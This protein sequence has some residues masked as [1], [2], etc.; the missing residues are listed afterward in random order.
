[1]IATLVLVGCWLELVMVVVAVVVV[2]GDDSCVIA[3]VKIFISFTSRCALPRD[4]PSLRVHPISRLFALL[5]GGRLA[6][7]CQQCHH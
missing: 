6:A 7:S 3:D 4:Y 5:C 1:M 2:V